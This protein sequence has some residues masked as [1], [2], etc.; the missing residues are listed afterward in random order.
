MR[1]NQLRTDKMRY[2]ETKRQNM[3]DENR[4]EKKI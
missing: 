1:R 4:T 2:D 3:R